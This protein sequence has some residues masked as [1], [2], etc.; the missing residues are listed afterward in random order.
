M[1]KYL[2]LGD[3]KLETFEYIAEILPDGHLSIPEAIIKRLKL[4]AHSKLRIFIV[5]IEKKNKDLS[6]FCGKWQEPREADEIVADIYKSRS[7]N[8]RS[9]RV[10]L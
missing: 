8:I 3:K 4:K 1:V 6:R 9:E 2:I 5:P 10:E 7:K